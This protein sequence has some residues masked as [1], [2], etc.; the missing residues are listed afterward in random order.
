VGKKFPTISKKKANFGV[1]GGREGGKE[2]RFWGK[3]TTISA[4]RN[5]RE[6]G[7][8]VFP[9]QFRG[10]KQPIGVG[11]AFSLGKGKDGSRKPPQKRPSSCLLQEKKKPRD[12]LLPTSNPYS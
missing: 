12:S 6:M 9:F 3:E 8:P 5:L 1:I 4:P 10:K 7:D 2:S 11:G